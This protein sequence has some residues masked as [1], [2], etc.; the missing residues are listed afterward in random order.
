MIHTENQFVSDDGLKL[1]RQSWQ[2]ADASKAVLAIVHG[3]GEHSGRYMNVVNYMVPIGIEICSYDHR[4]H[5][6]SEGKRGHILNWSEF[7]SDLKRFLQLIRSEKTGKPLF[8]MGHSMGGLILLNYL[9]YEKE[10]VRAVIASSPLLAQPAISPLLVTISRIL[11]RISPGFSIDTNLNAEH[12][13]RDS[14]VVKE[15][16]EDTL[17]HSK[18]SARFGTELTAAIEWTQSHAS[19]FT[20]PLMVIHGTADGL[21]PVE[22]SQ[23]FYD[24][25]ALPDKE[26]HLYEDGYHES[27]NDIHKE[28]VLKDY[29][30]WIN[31]HL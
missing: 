4:G 11:S 13:S 28:T 24:R 1:Y 27:H 12:I 6:R 5:G 9:M 7:R 17:V 14:N 3:F 2:D 29:E 23:E 18:A 26:L 10:D 15:Y 21:V 16:L 25:V 20:L 22:G 31:R 30:N 8:I 19:E